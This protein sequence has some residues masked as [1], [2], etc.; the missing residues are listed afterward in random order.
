MTRLSFLCIRQSALGFAALA[1]QDDIPKTALSEIEALIERVKS[2]DIAPRD[3]QL[4]ERLLRLMLS[5][6]SLLEHKNASIVC[7]QQA[8]VTFLLSP[9]AASR[10]DATF[11]LFP[12]SSAHYSFLRVNERMLRAA[13]NN[14]RYA[15]FRIMRSGVGERARGLIL[16]CFYR[17]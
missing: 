4:I 2:S 11:L 5:M 13:V 8:G 7:R 17:A 1:R 14:T 15:Q 10:R 9:L 6:A 12:S 16:I 3:A